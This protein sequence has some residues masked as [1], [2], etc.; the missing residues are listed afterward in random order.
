MLIYGAMDT[1]DARRLKIY[2]AIN[3]NSIAVQVGGEGKC[4]A[5]LSVEFRDTQII[6]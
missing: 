3:P 5:V 4:S 1:I 6:S 2:A